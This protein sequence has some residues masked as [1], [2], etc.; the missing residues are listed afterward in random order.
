MKPRFPWL[1]HFVLLGT[2]VLTLAP[3]AFMVNNAFR[4]TPEF[5]HGFFALPAAA[6]GLV[7]VSAHTLTGDNRPL[8]LQQDDGTVVKLSR[9]EAA[10][11]HWTRLTTGVVRAWQVLRPYVVNSFIVSGLTAVGVCCLGSGT[12]YILASHRFLGRQ[13]LFLFIL[14][15]MVFPGVLTLVPSFL[16][17][18]QLGLLDTYA[19]MILPYIAGGQVFAIFVFKS[20]FEGL[21]EELFE[22]ARLDG[23]GHWSLYRHIVLPLSLP[24]FS[25]VAI[26]NLL[27]T[28]NNFL[29][30]Y[31][32]SSDDRHAVVASGLFLLSGSSFVNDVGTMF[33]AYLLSSVPLLVLFLFATKTFV[34]GLT[35]GA[36]K[37]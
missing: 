10:G 15:T 36:M 28:W 9:R 5:Y 21:P 19:A 7:Q 8:T 31:I 25:V 23:A 14:S 17:V 1:I 4:S 18:K 35:S 32:V 20:F 12:A 11:R 2:A 24:I 33:A 37:V 30:P 16:L 34:R 26:M 6:K 22:S 13:F 3:F 27:G 29:W